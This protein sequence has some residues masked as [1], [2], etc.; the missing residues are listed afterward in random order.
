MRILSLLIFFKS[1]LLKPIN[2]DDE[3]SKQEN[4]K[5]NEKVREASIGMLLEIIKAYYKP[6][7]ENSNCQL[8]NMFNFEKGEDLETAII[9]TLIN[10]DTLYFF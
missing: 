9:R 2:K 3:K 10:G 8:I 6:I 1:N 4:A 7:K 5:S